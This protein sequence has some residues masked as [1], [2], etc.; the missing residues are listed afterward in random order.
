MEE[1]NVHVCKIIDHDKINK[2]S[3]LSF[4]LFSVSSTMDLTVIVILLKHR[5]HV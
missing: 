2:Y 4:T 5:S 3:E 1:N